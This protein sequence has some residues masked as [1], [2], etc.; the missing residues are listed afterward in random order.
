MKKILVAI[1]AMGFVGVA[2]AGEHPGS[3][4]GG[5]AMDDKKAA[6]GAMMA[7]TQVIIPAKASWVSV[8][9]PKGGPWVASVQGD[10]QKEAF[11]SFLKLKAGGN[12]GWHTHDSDYSGVVVSGTATHQDQGGKEHKLLPGQAWTSKAGVNH[13]NKCV[14]KTDCVL[15]IAVRGAFS[16]H[17]MTAEGKAVE[18]APAKTN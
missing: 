10:S 9:D 17:P 7:E 6:G 15:F 4:H 14:G 12:S 1:V 13:V 18:M 5:K 16:F 8:G 2:F 11:T 3:E